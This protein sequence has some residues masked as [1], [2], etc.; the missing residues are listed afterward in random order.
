MEKQQR[1]KRWTKEQKYSKYKAAAIL[2]DM[3]MKRVPFKA[4][5]MTNG[6]KLNTTAGGIYQ[7][8]KCWAK[9]QKQKK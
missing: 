8:Q 3:Q 6:N 2:G 9:Q 1:P 4:N 5:L 7:R